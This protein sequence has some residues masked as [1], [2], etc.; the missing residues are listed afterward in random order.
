MAPGWQ[1]LSLLEGQG[2]TPI[3]RHNGLPVVRHSSSQPTPFLVAQQH[4]LLCIA[5]NCMLKKDRRPRAVD[6]GCGN[7]RNS[8]YLKS[9]SFDVLSFDRKPDY[10]CQFELGEKDLPVPNGTVNVV[11]LQYVMMF[12]PCGSGM[13]PFSRVIQQTVKMMTSPSMAVV[14]LADVKNSLFHGKHLSD[15]LDV[16][17]KMFRLSFFQIDRKGL[18]MV[19]FRGI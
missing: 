15:L 14:E 10:G 13:S 4:R 5:V 17:E 12:L 11:L 8:E 16:V 18:K 3:S 1:G 6:L 7:G 2:M 19:A 9:L